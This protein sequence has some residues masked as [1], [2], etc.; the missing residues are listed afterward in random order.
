M[1]KMIPFVTAA[2]VVVA[3]PAQAATAFT[4]ITRYDETTQQA[5][6][7][8][9][10]MQI[11]KGTSA[12]TFSPAREIT[13]GQ[14]VKML[15]RYL[16]STGKE[17]PANWETKARFSDVPLAVK[18]R[19]LLQYAALVYDEGVFVGSEGKLNAAG[20][21]T[22]ENLVLVLSRL[23]KD[24]N[25]AQYVKD[26]GLTSNVK[27]LAA[28]KAE[29]KEAV[30]LFNALGIS[31]VEVFNPKNAVLRVHFASFLAKLLQTVEKMEQETANGGEEK[32]T[33]PDEEDEAVTTPPSTGGTTP[34]TTG[35]TTPPTTGET[36][37][38]STGG[39]TPPTTGETTPPTTGGTT[40][41]TTGETTPP[42]EEEEEPTIPDEEEEEPTIP[43]E[44]EE[45]P[46]IPDEEEEEPTYV[47]EL[48]DIENAQV[49]SSSSNEVTIRYNNETVKL[50]VD[51]SLAR[52]FNESAML[53]G[54]IVSLSIEDDIITDLNAI[55]ITNN[56]TAS[57]PVVI[58]GDWFTNFIPITIRSQYANVVDF[59]DY[60]DLVVVD[61]PA[62]SVY[63]IGLG[64]YETI[65]ASGELNITFTA[66]LETELLLDA[67]VTEVTI[68]RNAFVTSL[69]ATNEISITVQ[70]GGHLQD[71]YLPAHVDTLTMQGDIAN[72]N[73]ETTGSFTLKGSGN[74]YGLFGNAT[75]VYAEAN[76][77]VVDDLYVDPS[78]DEV[79]I[80]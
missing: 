11:V 4:D 16:Q 64:E 3:A 7:Y 22:R 79:T 57:A 8:L 20:M 24:A 17:I 48:E 34:P 28:V 38:P 58:D 73:V 27:D 25:L 76:G 70:E 72:V 44:E 35:E 30:Q 74:V 36:T 33:V 80:K 53:D 37:P 41:P 40:P 66:L 60:F 69:T 13:R 14:V 19:E 39:T 55:E 78:V 47:F 75:A 26:K 46:T 56:G 29:A 9:V 51:L 42:D 50:G 5:V 52:I 59:D 68:A 1:K 32:P 54:A 65:K 45:E 31:N 2:A 23:A 12:T 62:N 71:L 18:D 49:V 6:N 10:D 43:D 15:G 63:T 77:V 67:P 21:L 61:A